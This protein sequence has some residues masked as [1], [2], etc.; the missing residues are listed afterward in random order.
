MDSSRGGN[1]SPGLEV[2]AAIFDYGGQQGSDR[3]MPPSNLQVLARGCNERFLNSSGVLE[4]PH[5]AEMTYYDTLAGGFVFA[6]GS[7]TF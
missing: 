1:A 5:A 6:A 3:G 2:N 4:G 7:M